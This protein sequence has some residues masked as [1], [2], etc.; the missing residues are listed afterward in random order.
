MGSSPLIALGAFYFQNRATK[1]QLVQEIQ[2]RV[3]QALAPRVELVRDS[4]VAN[5]PHF[6]I[7]GVQN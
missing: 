3:A 7:V 6:A 5:Y 2:A 4:S 1:T